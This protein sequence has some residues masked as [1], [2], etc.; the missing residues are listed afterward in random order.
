[1]VNISF[2]GAQCGST[3]VAVPVTVIPTP[4]PT[5]NGT[6]INC[7][8]TATLTASTGIIYNWFSDAAGTTQVGTGASWTTPTLNATTT[9]YVGSAA[10]QASGSQSFSYNGSVQT[11]TAPSTGTYTLEV[12]GAKGGGGSNCYGSGGNGGYSKGDVTLNAGQTIYLAL[13]QQGFQSSSMNAYNGGG[14]GNPNGNDPG[15][16]GGG[17]THIATSNGTLASLSG[18]QNAVLVVAG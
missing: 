6:T 1:M 5:A 11:F 4:P 17:A 10:S 16:T 7:G 2:A 18:N 3:L 15:Y 12:W 13:G 8:Q 9:Y 14:A